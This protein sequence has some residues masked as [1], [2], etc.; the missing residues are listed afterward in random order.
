MLLSVPETIDYPF[1]LFICYTFT[2]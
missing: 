1:I 2:R